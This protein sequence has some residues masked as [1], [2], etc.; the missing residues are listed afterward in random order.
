MYSVDL[1]FDNFEK[2]IGRR[3]MNSWTSAEILKKN[4]VALYGAGNVGQIF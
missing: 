1:L 2:L 3:G 4:E